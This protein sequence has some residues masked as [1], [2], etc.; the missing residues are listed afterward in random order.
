M[1]KAS[2]FVAL[3]AA[4][5]FAAAGSAITNGVPDGSAHPEVGALL[6]PHAFSDR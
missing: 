6:A 3:S 1:R 4:L 2:L 5:V